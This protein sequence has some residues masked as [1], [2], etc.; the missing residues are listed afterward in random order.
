MY[1]IRSYYDVLQLEAFDAT[2]KSI[3]N[4]TWPI[5]YAADYFQKQRTLIS[6]DETALFTE[7]DSTVTLSAKH[8]TVTFTKQDGKI[9][10]VLNSLNKQVP[11]KEGPVAVGMKMKPIRSTCRMDGTDAVFCVITSYSIHY[12]KLY[13]YFAAS[14]RL[15]FL[16]QRH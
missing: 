5:H 1:A 15:L 16:L 12:T 8:V 13:D 2:G 3:C 14:Q 10:S 6:S 9:I 7:S 11:F 4:W